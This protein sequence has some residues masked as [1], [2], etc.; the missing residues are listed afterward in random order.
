M[1]K[2]KEVSPGGAK[3]VTWRIACSSISN[4]S[5]RLIGGES[6]N[7]HS[8]FAKLNVDNEPLSGDYGYS[9]SGNEL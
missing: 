7:D 4:T 3:A 9:N 5:Y 2:V 8:G 1:L 6:S